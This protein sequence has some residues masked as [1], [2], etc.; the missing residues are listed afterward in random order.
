M[1]ISDELHRLAE[2]LKQGLLSQAE[3]EVAKQRLLGSSQASDHASDPAAIDE[4]VAEPAEKGGPTNSPFSRKVVEVVEGGDDRLYLSI[5]SA[6]MFISLF[7]PWI[8]VFV[9][10]LN[11]FDLFRLGFEAN[12]GLGL[13]RSIFG[14]RVPSTAGITFVALIML[15]ATAANVLAPLRASNVMRYRQALTGSG[16]VLAVWFIG[17]AEAVE[18]L[19][20]FGVSLF[21]IAAASNA[22]LSGIQLRRAGL[23]NIRLDLRL[24]A[25]GLAFLLVASIFNRL[26]SVGGPLLSLLAWS[27]VG[28]VAFLLIR[29]REGSPSSAG[30]TKV[31]L[32]L[33][34]AFLLAVLNALSTLGSIAGSGPSFI[35][36]VIGIGRLGVLALGITV[37][38]RRHRMRTQPT[39]QG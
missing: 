34:S 8:S 26:L 10:D 24:L 4:S 38:Y 18:G 21:L 27:L 22:L 5:G 25:G 15:L 23:L 36:V 20:S 37:V 12:R 2:L 9:A 17:I 35:S 31:A 29:R 6:A 19:T 13:L 39:G 14:D 30:S 1:S 7:L 16:I 28:G 32:L 11:A 33:D 3:Y